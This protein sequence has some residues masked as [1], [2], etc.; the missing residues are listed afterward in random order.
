MEFHLEGVSLPN[1]V[2]FRLPCVCDSFGKSLAAGE[3]S[4]VGGDVNKKPEVT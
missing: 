3:G 4:G 2:K 1:T